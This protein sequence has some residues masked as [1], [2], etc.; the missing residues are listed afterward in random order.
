MN[1]N[2]KNYFKYILGIITCLLIRFIPFRPPNVEP[3]LATSMP[4]SK[5]YGKVAGFLFA[6]SSIVLYDVISTKVGMWTFVTAVAYGLIGIW[7]V[8]FFRNRASTSMNYM[9]FA[10]VSTIAYDLVT[11]L[12]VGPIYFSQPFLQALM[13]QIPFTL[14]HLAGNITF[15]GLFSPLIYRYIVKS[16]KLERISFINI[17]NPKKI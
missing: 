7:A 1:T 17:F 10:V 4:F 15:A 11:G 13:G 6:F 12:T 14:L 16:E 2:K 3:L 8:Y 5:E 9:K